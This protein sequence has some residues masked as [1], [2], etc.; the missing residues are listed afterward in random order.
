MLP[1]RIFFSEFGQIQANLHKFAKNCL[2]QNFFPFF[3]RNLI[4]LCPKKY[5]KKF[6][7]QKC[8]IFGVKIIGLKNF[9]VKNISFLESTFLKCS[10]WFLQME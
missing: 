1:L 4:K 8:S 2:S 3:G 7:G 6:W 5:G 9:G 10:K